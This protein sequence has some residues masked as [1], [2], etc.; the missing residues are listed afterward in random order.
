MLHRVLWVPCGFNSETNRVYLRRGGDGAR[1]ER[2][3]VCVNPEARDEVVR[4]NLVAY[5]EKRIAGSGEW[6]E[7][8]RDK[9]VGEFRASPG[10]APFCRATEDHKLRVDKAAIARDAYFDGKWLLHTSDDT[11][12]STD[13]ANASEQRYRV[14]RGR[15]HGKGA[16]RLRPVFHQHEERIRSHVQ[17][18]LGLLFSRVIEHATG[19]TWRNVRSELDRMH[20][21]TLGSSDSRITKRSV[22]TK[23]PRRSLPRSRCA[24]QPRSS[25]TSSP[26]RSNSRRSK[27]RVGTRHRKLRA[28]IL[29]VQLLT[30]L[31]SCAYELSES[32]RTAVG[33]GARS[34]ARGRAGGGHGRVP[35]TARGTSQ[36]WSSRRALGP[37]PPRRRTSPACSRRCAG[38]PAPSARPDGAVPPAGSRRRDD[39]PQSLDASP[40]LLDRL[41][42]RS[43]LSASLN[44]DGRVLLRRY[45][46]L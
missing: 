34:C 36:R 43:A 42:S 17:L 24:S 2:F 23:D 30:L 7:Q 5:L 6:S 21:V 16:L 12:A 33:S 44:G 14:G 41:A 27:P 22:T 39:D 3:G 20:L 26:P 46:G 29:P 28:A 15:T 19:D 10:L 11:L 35:S 4:A 8:R 25:T 18:W 31:G 38:C 9:P 32:G 1:A 13:L 40:D 45:T 37:C